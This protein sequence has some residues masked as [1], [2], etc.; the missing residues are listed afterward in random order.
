MLRQRVITAL[1]LVALLL[2]ALFHATPEPLAGLT[3]LLIAAGAWEW[4]RLNQL[5]FKSAMGLALAC[6][7]LCS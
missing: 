3:L 6:L 1:I 4:G 2:P 7:A 5:D